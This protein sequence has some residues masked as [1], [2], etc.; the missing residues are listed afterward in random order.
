[1]FVNKY[2]SN[3]RPKLLRKSPFIAPRH[4]LPS[5]SQVQG[6]R[7][8]MHWRY[9]FSLTPLSISLYVPLHKYARV[10]SPLYAFTAAGEHADPK[11]GNPQRRK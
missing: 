9:L 1:M 8:V 4:S 10:S 7:D 6:P 5:T 3:L 2:F 11:P